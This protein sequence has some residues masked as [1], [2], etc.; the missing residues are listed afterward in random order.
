MTKPL[1]GT[2]IVP[3]PEDDKCIPEKRFALPY[4]VVSPCPKCGT[5]RECDL[6][7]EYLRYPSLTEPVPVWLWCEPCA[8]EW[9]VYLTLTFSIRLTD[10]QPEPKP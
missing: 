1:T 7:R 9:P 3:P 8:A 6:W 10:P 4:S 2:R 5:G